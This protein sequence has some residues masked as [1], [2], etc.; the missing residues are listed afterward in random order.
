MIAKVITYPKLKEAIEIAFKGD[1]RIYD[2]YDPS[3]KVESLEAIVADIYRKIT[4]YQNPVLVGIYE[5]E[6]LIGYFV[7]QGKMLIS[8]SLSIQYRVRKYLKEFFVIISK[9]LKK[10]FHCYLWTKNIRAI[11]WLKKNGLQVFNVN[12]HIVQLVYE[13]RLA[14]NLIYN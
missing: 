6:G 12:P 8:F 13:K 5:R 2:F 10:D 11:K 4:T 3:V 7:Y 1:N 14:N 9:E